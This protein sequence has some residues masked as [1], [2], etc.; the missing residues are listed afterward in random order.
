MEVKEFCKMAILM[1]ISGQ[2]IPLLPETKGYF[3][4]IISLLEQGEKYKNIVDDLENW[5]VR[6]VM[7]IPQ[8]YLG[9]QG[10]AMQYIIKITKQKYFPSQPVKKVITIEVEGG[11]EESFTARFE[12]YL[13]EIKKYARGNTKVNIKEATD[14]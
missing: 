4:R 9:I 6:R 5:D 14:D 13:G 3:E 10:G 11:C 12:Y 7:E 8:K 1:I 2:D